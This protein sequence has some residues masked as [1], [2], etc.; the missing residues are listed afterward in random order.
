MCC[1]GDDLLIGMMNKVFDCFVS[2]VM[3]VICL[4]L[5]ESVIFLMFLCVLNVVVGL[6][7]VIVGVVISKIEKF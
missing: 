2:G 3:N 6:I 7:C 1:G 4:L 5:G